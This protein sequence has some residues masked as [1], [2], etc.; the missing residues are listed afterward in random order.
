M[1]LSSQDSFLVMGCDGIYEKQTNASL[2]KWIQN[3]FALTRSPPEAEESEE[4]NMGLK[5][6]AH[7]TVSNGVVSNGV[8]SGV[9]NGVVSGNGVVS[10]GNRASNAGD[11]DPDESDNKDEES[12]DSDD[13]RRGRGAAAAKQR[14]LE[15]GSKVDGAPAAVSSAAVGAAV[16]SSTAASSS[17]AS[18]SKESASGKTVTVRKTKQKNFLTKVCDSFVM[19]N[20]AHSPMSEGGLG[21]D[22]MSILILQFNRDSKLL[23][24]DDSSPTQDDNTSDMEEGEGEGWQEGQHSGPRIIELPD[25]DGEDD[26]DDDEDESEGEESGEEKKSE[27]KE[28]KESKAE[29][30]FEEAKDGEAKDGESAEGDV[31]MKEDAEKESGE[32][33]SKADDSEE[34]AEVP[35]TKKQKTEE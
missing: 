5:A 12:E 9:S 33:E 35:P 28:A 11:A 15:D 2:V 21:C 30:K 16:S 31:E 1:E 25:Q 34:A 13:D 27:K 18:K 7:S 8:V 10:E 29:K 4:E 26:D 14:K 17:Q 32:K 22:N 20:L 24:L 6:H 19:F 23:G 3:R